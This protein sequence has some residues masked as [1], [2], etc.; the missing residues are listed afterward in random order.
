MGYT[1]WFPLW[2]GREMLSGWSLV[3]LWRPVTSA[4]FAHNSRRFY[5]AKSVITSWRRQMTDKCRRAFFSWGDT[6]SKIPTLHS[7]APPL[8]PPRV[9]M[10]P[11]SNPVLPRLPVGAQD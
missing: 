3:R 9:E 8:L 2:L 6:A 4:L 11:G 5:G 7:S 10:I 1:L